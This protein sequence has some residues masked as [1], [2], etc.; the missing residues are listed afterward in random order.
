MSGQAVL[1]PAGLGGFM[2]ISQKQIDTRIEQLTR[3]LLC[4]YGLRVAKKI[5]AQV[6]KNLAAEYRRRKNL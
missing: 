1:C 2:K 6:K 5:V 3:G 4:E